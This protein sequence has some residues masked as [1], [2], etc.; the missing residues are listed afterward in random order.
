ML[1]REAFDQTLEKYRIGAK[2]LADAAG[3]SDS[4]VSQF[5]R[6]KKGMT[7]EMLDKLL[8]AMETIAPGSRGYFC[9]LLA[10]RSLSERGILVGSID[11]I[12]EEEIP[13]LLI[14]IA[15]RWHSPVEL[16]G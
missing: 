3:V 1:I 8:K 4:T 12:P 9:S 6:G 14:S 11:D 5:R 15:R 2:M 10:D 13:R 16:I 7:D